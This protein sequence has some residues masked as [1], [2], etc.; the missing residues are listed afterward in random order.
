M[1]T[2]NLTKIFFSPI[3]GGCLAFNGFEEGSSTRIKSP[4]CAKSFLSR[5]S[6]TDDCGSVRI[7]VSYS[8]CGCVVD[9][10]CGW[11]HIW[12]SG[13][14]DN[15][16]GCVDDCDSASVCDCVWSWNW[17]QISDFFL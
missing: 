7:W 8:V 9:C 10:D 16:F 3:V 6:C 1:F 15:I 13:C 14:A 4:S 12:V 11:V 5:W 17:S 2:T